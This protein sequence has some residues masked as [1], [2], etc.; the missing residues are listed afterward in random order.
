MG[1]AISKYL[2]YDDLQWKLTTTRFKEW[3][4][5]DVF[6]LK[7]WGLLA[8]FIL[9][10]LVWWKLVD[11][12]RLTELILFA[13]IVTIIILAL[14]ELGEELTLWDYP[15]EIFPLFPPI[16]SIDLASLPLVYSLIYQY[17]KTWKSYTIASIIMSILSCFVLEPLFV[18]SGIYQMIT[19]KSYYGL[20]LYFAIAIFAK[21]VLIK[22]L[23]I[24]SKQKS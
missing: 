15:V 14:D 24:N 19:W 6:R 18:L 11:K 10:I 3:V 4:S 8:I 1:Y 20:P 22:I 23:A 7:W 21:I 12:S 2:S 17:F 5:D 9:S 13:G 16:A